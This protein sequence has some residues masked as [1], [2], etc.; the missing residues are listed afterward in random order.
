MEHKLKIYERE[1]NVKYNVNLIKILLEGFS[2]E[3]F[4][5]NASAINYKLTYG[6]LYHIDRNR[7]HIK[8]MV[9]STPENLIN[10]ICRSLSI[11]YKDDIEYRDLLS[12]HKTHR[13]LKMFNTDNRLIDQSRTERTINDIRRA[14]RDA[15]HQITNLEKELITFFSS[16][17]IVK[18]DE[19]LFQHNNHVTWD[20]IDEQSV[21][22]TILAPLT[23][24]N[25]DEAEVLFSEAT[26]SFKDVFINNKNIIYFK[27]S[28]MLDLVTS[29][30][31][32]INRNDY[33]G[34]PH[35]SRY[36]CWSK[37]QSMAEKALYSRNIR[38]CV[39]YLSA[40]VS[41]LTLSDTTVLGTFMEHFKDY[42]NKRIR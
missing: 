10:A 23:I 16:N 33:R 8:C 9:T 13:L 31:T 7:K 30:I 5:T 27:N 11:P 12:D 19:S 3:V 42:I 14:I 34:N 1:L 18:S 24:Y 26:D 2:L 6:E 4:T 28:F 17:E 38:E 35:I 25:R 36:N 15:Y 32:L 41:T 22:V 37:Y 39:G 40:A 20:V 29:T 21:S